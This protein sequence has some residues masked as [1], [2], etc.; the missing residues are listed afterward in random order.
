MSQE[1]NPIL[2]GAIILFE[3]FMTQWEMLSNLKA[4]PHMKALLKPSL[5]KTYKYYDRMDQTK[6]YVITMCK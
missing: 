1:S 3:T 6:V 5:T 4:K 2:S